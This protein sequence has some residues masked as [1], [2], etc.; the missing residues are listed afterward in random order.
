MTRQPLSRPIIQVENRPR[1]RTV[2][3]SFRVVTKI[4]PH[5]QRNQSLEIDPDPSVGT[6]KLGRVSTGVP[7]LELLIAAQ[8]AT[9][10]DYICYMVEPSGQVV[11]L[12]HLC[13]GSGSETA[14]PSAIG[15]TSEIEYLSYY[16]SSVRAALA[17]RD[18]LADGYQYCEM[19]QTMTRQELASWRV[20]QAAGLSGQDADRISDHW[21]TV[22]VGTSLY[23]CP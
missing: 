18:P 6:L 14:L 4:Y 1:M 11:N 17:E 9:S 10:S 16:N 5:T 3:V 13:G 7:M 8:V 12:A 2:F 15:D 22:S 20:D 19:R 21:T 23:L